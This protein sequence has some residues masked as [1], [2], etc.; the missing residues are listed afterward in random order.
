MNMPVLDGQAIASLVS[1][2]MVLVLWVGVLRNKRAADAARDQKLIER[3][4]RIDA[5]R[6]R[7]SPTPPQDTS[8][9]SGPW[10]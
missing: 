1:M 6:A 10:G 3:Q 8:D 4:E 7:Q 2:L 9:K 5:E